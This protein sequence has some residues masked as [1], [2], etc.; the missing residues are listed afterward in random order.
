MTVP[1]LTEGLVFTDVGIKM[2]ENINLKEH[3]TASTRQCLTRML[4][5]NEVIL[6]EERFLSSTLQCLIS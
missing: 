2:F 4:A 6:K 5:Y 1:E 3:Q